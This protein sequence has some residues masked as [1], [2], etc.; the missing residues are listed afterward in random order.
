MEKSMKMGVNLEPQTQ[1][2]VILNRKRGDSRNVIIQ[3]QSAQEQW[4]MKAQVGPLRLQA[5]ELDH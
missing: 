3:Q 1:T 5:E 4:A 2:N